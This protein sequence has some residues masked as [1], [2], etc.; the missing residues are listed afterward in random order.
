MQ[1]KCLRV[2][3]PKM[4]IL[5]PKEN[6]TC[7][8][9][10]VSM[11][12]GTGRKQTAR[13]AVVTKNL[14]DPAE[15]KSKQNSGISKRRIEICDPRDECR[16]KMNEMLMFCVKCKDV[17]KFSFTEMK[18]HCQQKHPDDK[19]M[20]VCSRCGFTVD[21][22]ERMNS[23]AISY[24]VGSLLNKGPVD[25][26]EGQSSRLEGKQ[27]KTR[28]LKPDTL[29][30]NKCRFST[31]DPLQFQKH[32]LRHDEIQYK[33]GRC[34]HVCYTRGEFQRHSV[35]HTGT[36]PF[37]CRY[38][39]YG[40][41]RKDY[42]VKHTKGVHRDIVK[43][44]GSVL[45]LP[46][47]KGPKKALPKPS[48]GLKGKK[49]VTTQN[50]NSVNV[51][52]NNKMSDSVNLAPNHNTTSCEVQDLDI[53][54]LPQTAI[55]G[56]GEIKSWEKAVEHAK[57]LNGFPSDARKMR[58]QVLASSK[59]IVQPGTPLTL[60]A[61][62]QVVI[63]SNCLAQL[64]EIK[65]V[66]GKQQLVFKLIPQ[67]LASSCPVLG[68]DTSEMATSSSSEMQQNVNTES[69]NAQKNSVTNNSPT[70]VT[71]KFDCSLFPHFDSLNESFDADQSSMGI[72]THT[73][74]SNSQ[75]LGD[76]AR[77]SSRL[78]IRNR[79]NPKWKQ[80]V[81]TDQM[82]GREP[83]TTDSAW[84][85]QQNGFVS[86]D[87]LRKAVHCQLQGVL[88]SKTT[89]INL[90]TDTQEINDELGNESLKLSGSNEMQ[91]SKNSYLTNE[92]VTNKGRESVSNGEQPFLS[93]LSNKCLD[94]S[95][96]AFEKPFAHVLPNASAC[97]CDQQ[98]IDSGHKSAIRPMESL[99]AD[100]TKAKAQFCITPCSAS[101]EG[102]T[103]APLQMSSTSSSN[104]ISAFKSGGH[105]VTPNFSPPETSLV[106]KDTN[107][108]QHLKGQRIVN[109]NKQPSTVEAC[110]SHSESQS[111]CCAAKQNPK[112]VSASCL[113]PQ[114]NREVCQIGSLFPIFRKCEKNRKTPNL[115]LQQLRALE[116]RESNANYN[117]SGHS[118]QI[119]VTKA[120]KSLPK[121]INCPSSSGA[122]VNTFTTKSM[123]SLALMN[124]MDDS[125]E[126]IKE[127]FL[128][129]DSDAQYAQDRLQGIAV[130][131]DFN[132][133][134][135]FKGNEST[136]DHLVDAQW[137]IISSVFSLCSG[138]DVVP[139]GIRWNHN[140]DDVCPS[141]TSAQILKPNLC[142]LI[143]A[144]STSFS[145]IFVNKGCQ[146]SEPLN[147]KNP[148]H[149][150]KSGGRSISTT[151]V[152]S[153]VIGSPFKLSRDQNFAESLSLFPPVS[154]IEIQDGSSAHRFEQ[155]DDDVHM[156][157]DV[158]SLYS[159]EFYLN[160][161]SSNVCLG[162]S[163]TNSNN[164]AVEHTVPVD[165]FVQIKPLSSMP[166]S[167]EHSL[168]DVTQNYQTKLV[169][170]P[171][172]NV[173]NLSPDGVSIQN[174]SLPN[175]PSSSV[176]GFRNPSVSYNVRSTFPL[177]PSLSGMTTNACKE[178][179][180]KQIGL[181]DIHEP[182]ACSFEGDAFN[183]KM[184]FTEEVQK[185]MPVTTMASSVKLR[186]Q[187]SLENKES[188]FSS[189][190]N[191]KNLNHASAVENLE[192]IPHSLCQ[193][194]QLAEK[195]MLP[196][197]T[198]PQN[199]SL[200][201]SLGT[202]DQNN[203]TKV[204]IKPS[205][206][207]SRTHFM[208]SSSINCLPLAADVA[209]QNKGVGDFV[210]YQSADEIKND[211]PNYPRNSGAGSVSIG[212]NVQ[213]PLPHLQS[214]SKMSSLCTSAFP[215]CS[216]KTQVSPENAPPPCHR[217]KDADCARR[218]TTY[219]VVSS[220]I[221]LRVLNSA[222]DSKQKVTAIG[223]HSMNHS[224]NFN[225]FCTSSVS[226][227]TARKSEI[228]APFVAKKQK[229]CS[230]K[231]KYHSNSSCDLSD[232]LV[233]EPNLCNA[234]SL[235]STASQKS[236]QLKCSE[237]LP[238][239]RRCTRKGK[240]DHVQHNALFKKI[241]KHDSLAP[242]ATNICEVLKTARKLRLKPFNDSQLVKCPRRNQP[243][244]V[245]NHPDVEVQEVTNVMQ[246]IGK[247]RGHVLK[248]VLSERTVVSLNLKRKKTEVGNWNVA[249]DRW[250]NCKV[251]SPVK[252]RLM[253]KMKLK[254]IHKNN[255]QIVKNT[256][257]EH[258][259]FK[260]HCW[261]CGRMFCDQEEWI[262]HGQR[263]LMEATRDWNDVTKIQETTENGTEVLNVEKKSNI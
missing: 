118:H 93:R 55:T 3:L 20:F 183:Q 231:S 110:E 76:M 152:Q 162:Q 172:L 101:L 193:T 22:V 228:P 88:D 53:A 191:S 258:L 67:A 150:S 7:T 47:R 13:K 185:D 188:L 132:N 130:D 95:D 198:V 237:E 154:P 23:H 245:L 17:Q 4:E 114:G 159:D 44:G 226:N 182:S 221:V 156:V 171:K 236:R 11:K 133:Q 128:Y 15:H 105:R 64:I 232:I 28:H 32:V 197:A 26:K 243:V 175:T 36:F 201:S 250:H 69:S 70:F 157:K 170:P 25:S 141:F 68:S 121:H 256:Q 78:E 238:L 27:H 18:E 136:E 163:P 248:V 6:F 100:G 169:S 104:I 251:V 86:P 8:V 147:L 165:S 247:Y 119:L 249:C 215:V 42:V 225:V 134:Q 262:A 35:Q 210:N 74:H 186:H 81:T 158:Y 227:G 41:V 1:F 113:L 160:Q 56:P 123:N 125:S 84:G 253:L 131:A 111:M 181:A 222:D 57:H 242:V 31:K 66:N 257:N 205:G 137:P 117:K 103:A 149:V 19:P 99:L 49:I 62:A 180:Q 161:S 208:L 9:S 43:N 223:C 203:N 206:H 124:K 224:Q 58:L 79:S 151:A 50:E 139:E 21:D 190:C 33:C 218:E 207:T 178:K 196:H 241:E 240:A 91:K 107:Y 204:Q 254:K 229:N 255:Y 92:I 98:L 82:Q 122:A 195:S 263:H 75:S 39:D 29:Y 65:T 177:L 90:N 216:M 34:D 233:D 108:P 199:T 213:N 246:T 5:P 230:S 80:K 14:L 144:E 135:G 173:L 10:S 164:T 212:R 155:F 235:K 214:T 87:V 52:L 37:K 142:S 72:N 51:V 102:S 140:Q 71:K 38:C 2:L 259:Q 146:A 209:N 179:F 89:V 16:K 187:L 115:P 45:V 148:E 94:Y 129:F 40:A 63:P 116:H 189:S 143:Q 96:K 239:K 153:G 24:K 176:D 260:F 60:V 168:T 200:S 194:L 244:V 30:C 112:N 192:Q 85:L 46:I 106:S 109:V 211:K 54:V 138:S 73:I 217:I 12:F 220:G 59:H 83:M 145:N 127:R 234:T 166:S 61:P 202:D 252:E 120:H 167:T 174:K 77:S 184:C 261:F 97:L 126:L 219:K 48:N